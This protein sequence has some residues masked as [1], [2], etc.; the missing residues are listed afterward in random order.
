MP[1]KDI[2]H[3]AV[4][5]ALIKE[6]WKILAEDYVLAYG[7]DRVYADL[8]AERTIAAE[9]NNQRILVEVKSFL[10][11]SFIHDLEQAIGQY[12]LYRNI[13]EETKQ[14]FSL[15]LA[16]TSGVYESNFQK[17]LP[18]LIVKRNQVK[19]IIVDPKTEVIVKWTD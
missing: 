9:R 13:L 4:R 18:K 19:L 10:G 16:V 3:S 6:G 11:R 15:Y 7:T 14:D 12:I 1:K 8:A 17:E 2:Y 5:F